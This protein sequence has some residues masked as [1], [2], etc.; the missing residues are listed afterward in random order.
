MRN[1][2]LPAALLLAACQAPDAP[3]AQAPPVAPP[4]AASPYALPAP[5]PVPVVFGPDVIST[6]EFES[7]ASFTPDGQTL[8]FVRSEPRAGHW[9]IYQSHFEAGRWTTP[10]VAPFSGQFR[11]SDPYMT[12]DGRQL[13]FISDRPVD[14]VAKADMDIW[15]MD[16]TA[17]GWS[18]P[19]NPGAPLNSA[20]S[21]W[22]PTMTSRGTLYFG[23]SRSG[24]YGLTDIYRA[25]SG[26]GA[27]HV[28]NLG[29]P[30]N[31]VGYEYEPLIAADES[32]LIF[33]AYRPDAHGA[34]DLYIS[35]SAGST[36][37]AP[38]NL[39]PPINSTELEFGPTLS[40]DGKYLFFTS[41]RKFSSDATELTPPGN[42]NGDIYQVDLATALAAAAAPAH[43]P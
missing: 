29:A 11:D 40:P 34:S 20:Q 23:S 33:M 27:W 24:G 15:I 32:Y 1:A 21:E 42:G 16:R 31:T 19:H 10:G 8:Y 30:V 3:V 38:V 36:W 37:T 26:G 4:A 2:I 13:F 18:E 9:T 7:S 12:A 17:Q 25:T 41:T 39:G 5:A 22:H 28:Q 35:W 6:G 14:G 43:A